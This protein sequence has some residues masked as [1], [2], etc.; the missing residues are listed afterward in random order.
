MKK[1]DHKCITCKSGFQN[2]KPNQK[3]CSIVCLRE[4]KKNA[5]KAICECCNT[6]FLKYSSG[7]NMKYC[8]RVCAAKIYGE[9]RTTNGTFTTECGWCKKVITKRLSQK[10]KNGDYCSPACS[11]AFKRGNDQKNIIKTCKRC[12][13]EYEVLY[14]R[15]TEYCSRKCSSLY[16]SGEEHI[17]YGKEGPTKGMKPWTYGLT[18][19]NDERIV[20]L[21]AKISKIQKEQFA[22]GIRSNAKENNPNWGK[23]IVDRTFEQI[24]NYSKTAIKRVMTGT[25]GGF[26]KGT[27]ESL[28]AIKKK[29]YY[30]SS[31]EFKFMKLLDADKNVITYSYEPFYIKCSSGKRYLPDFLVYYSDGT[32]KLIE[33]KCEYTRYLKN[34]SDKEQ[35]AREYCKNNNMIYEILMLN[36]INEYEK[37]IESIII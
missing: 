24:E 22:S 10:G 28:K 23:T 3:Y 18:K 29:M 2:R 12:N 34:F 13:K 15:Q 26:I 5:R 31:Y 16:Q 27:H 7:S 17:N 4:D 30:R 20:E 36:D 9:Q 11:E 25:K 32:K 6:E 33:I 19:E 1:Y 37:Y 21:G 35:D 8:S 14:R